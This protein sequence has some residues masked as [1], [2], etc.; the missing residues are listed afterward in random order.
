MS[1]AFEVLVLTIGHGAGPVS[2]IAVAA[3]AV[4]EVSRAE[5]ITPYP[6]APVD[7]PGVTAIRGR[8][9]VILDLARRGEQLSISAPLVLL[10]SE[11]RAL[12]LAG[13]T[14]VR[15]AASAVVPNDTE[16]PTPHV[17]LWSARVLPVA[18]RV[19]LL[20]ATRPDADDGSMLP[21]LDAAAL[22]DD[23]I[24]DPDGGR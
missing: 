12:A 13:V 14:P 16:Q 11:G 1:R 10:E 2:R 7:I 23:V 18:G 3:S 19:R 21:L 22:I 9:V 6:G 15:V 4:R 24:D 8:I 5:R 20:D 17:R